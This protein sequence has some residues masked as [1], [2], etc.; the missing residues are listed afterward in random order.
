MPHYLCTPLVNAELDESIRRFQ[1]AMEAIATRDINAHKVAI[2]LRR[3]SNVSSRLFH[4]AE[5]CGLTAVLGVS[6]TK[7]SDADDQEATIQFEPSDERLG[8]LYLSHKALVAMR[9][10]YSNKERFRKDY[11]PLL[12][13][14]K[15]IGREVFQLNLGPRYWGAARAASKALRSGDTVIPCFED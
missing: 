14:V 9:N 15:A 5:R 1:G 8:E 4:V 2:A 12:A 6:A 7:E 11:L 3:D 10:S 13:L